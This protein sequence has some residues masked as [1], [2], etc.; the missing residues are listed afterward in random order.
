[1]NNSIAYIVCMWV[2]WYKLLNFQKMIDFDRCNTLMFHKYI[3]TFL[4]SSLL[5][6][7]VAFTSLI[8][9]LFCNCFHNNK[10]AVL[11]TAI[12]LTSES[13]GVYMAVS[14]NLIF[15]CSEMP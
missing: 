9:S 8:K 2:V 7:V 12:V 13:F 14:P 4:D 11:I 1:M 5:T 6:T 3:F 10:I 15:T